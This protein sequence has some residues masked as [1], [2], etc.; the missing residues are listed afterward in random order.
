MAQFGSDGYNYY[1]GQGFQ[2]FDPNLMP[3]FNNMAAQQQPFT[4]RASDP[5]AYMHM[6][7]NELA[8]AG[9]DMPVHHL[10]KPEDNMPWNGQFRDGVQ[11]QHQQ[12]DPRAW[13]GNV[14]ERGAKT[15][16]VPNQQTYIGRIGSQKSSD[17]SD[18]AY[19]SLPTSSVPV[20]NYNSN[21]QE[22]EQDFQS[23]CFDTLKSEHGSEVHLAISAPDPPRSVKSEGHHLTRDSRRRVQLVPC[24]WCGKQPKNLSDAKKHSLTHVK[25]HLCEEPNCE[26]TKGFATINDLERHKK[27]VHSLLPS[28]GSA[29]G[30]ICAACPV[31]D[32]G[33]Q[34][35]FW[36]RRDNF[37]AHIKRKHPKYHEGQLIEASKHDRRPDD[38]RTVEEDN[39]SVRSAMQSS[40]RSQGDYNEPQKYQM[41][42]NLSRTI[43]DQP[44]FGNNIFPDSA[45][46]MQQDNFAGMGEH[47]TDSSMTF[48]QYSMGSTDSTAADGFDL[49]SNNNSSSCSG[50]SMS[51]SPSKKPKL[52]RETLPYRHNPNPVFQITGPEHSTVSFASNTQS[53]AASSTVQGEFK[54]PKCDK[55]KRRDCD[56][57][58]HMKRHTRPYGCTFP[59]CHKKFGSRNDW[60][61]HESSQ[62]F[63]HEM[64]KCEAPRHDGTPCTRRPFR[65]IEALKKHLRGD[66]H[67]L[68]CTDD[69]ILAE[70]KRYLLGREGHE[71]F[72]CGFC[73]RLVSQEKA[74]QNAWDARFK[75]IGDHFDKEGKD[76]GDWVCIEENKAKRFIVPVEDGKGNGK[77]RGSYRKDGEQEEEAELPVFNPTGG[78]GFGGMGEYER[79]FVGFVGERQGLKRKCSAMELDADGE[80]DYEMN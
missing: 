16:P 36:P 50:F 56:L 77:R 48:P 67:R 4:H 64:Y 27:S 34:R 20:E 46:D 73:Q 24:S 55:V 63:L 66:D 59:S 68:Q 74:L 13:Q 30:Y 65:D 28:V 60:K 43:P 11:Q 38:A 58:K 31:P 49:L 26:R 2:G 23:P 80:S 72:W 17:V 33:S 75:H 5:L 47:A 6:Q 12:F 21:K 57:K 62:H 25:P 51:T 32:G 10:T 69:E 35:K 8:R 18:S 52:N 70:C 53:T 40:R 41:S 54:C 3:D 1:S 14:N 29:A 78:S 71:R 79:G 37:K 15:E 39:K 22:L 42:P 45:I 19:A 61:R 7:Y 76:S 9:R 44:D